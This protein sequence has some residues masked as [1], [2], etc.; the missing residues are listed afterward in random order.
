MS[1]GY[2]QFLALSLGGIIYIALLVASFSFLSLHSFRLVGYSGLA[3]FL[4][5]WPLYAAW[6]ARS[7]WPETPFPLRLAY[8]LSFKR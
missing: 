8:I 3:V 1:T 6:D 5:F 4:A 2:K 7:R